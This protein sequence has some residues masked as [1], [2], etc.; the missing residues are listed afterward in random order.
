MMV[1]LVLGKPLGLGCQAHDVWLTIRDIRDRMD[2]PSVGYTTVATVATILY[3][4][5]L[6][7]REP[8]I[9]RPGART[10]Q[11]QPLKSDDVAV[12][13]CH[14]LGASPGS[15]PDRHAG[16]GRREPVVGRGHAALAGR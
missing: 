5:D 16:E 13:A 7:L 6:L 2:Y 14:V 8:V 4:K 10:L 12:L 15:R 9:W 11:L 3:D 1:P